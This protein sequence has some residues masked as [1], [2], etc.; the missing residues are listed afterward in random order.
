MRPSPRQAW[1][2][3][4]AG[5]TDEPETCI[6]SATSLFGAARSVPHCAVSREAASCAAWPQQASR[7]WRGA[8]RSVNP[9]VAAALVLVRV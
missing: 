3:H 9:R 7:S 6:R 5:E 4:D 8:R 2:S 1:S